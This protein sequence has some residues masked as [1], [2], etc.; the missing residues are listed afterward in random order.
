MTVGKWNL[1]ALLRR[2][3]SCSVRKPNIHCFPGLNSGEV[4]PRFVIC[5]LEGG[6]DAAYVSSWEGILVIMH[7]L[8]T[9]LWLQYGQRTV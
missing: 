7:V 5:T 2:E 8:R 9:C 3:A 6:I 1:E 4:V